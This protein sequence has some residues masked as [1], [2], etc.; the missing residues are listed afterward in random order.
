MTKLKKFIRKG[1]NFKKCLRVKLTN[2]TRIFCI[3]RNKTGTTSVYEALNRLG[4]HVA[5]QHPAEKLL[6]DWSRR[7]FSALIKF[8][9]WYEAFQ[10]VPFSFPYTFQEVDRAFPDAKF[11]LTI[12][13]TPEE[14]YQSVKRFHAKMF[15]DGSKASAAELKNAEYCYKG[16]I[17]DCQRFVYGIEEGQEYDKEI[18]IK[19]YEFH[20]QA[21]KDYFRWQSHKLLVLNVSEPGAY[22]KLAAFLNL[23]VDPNASFP[24]ENK[25]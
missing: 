13:N 25:T 21:I 14:W 3:G 16:Y 4:Y 1:V 18:Y 22:Q 15:S 17:W 10:D 2:P 7:D 6:K 8:C 24:W 9:T 5:P 11:I 23:Q 20:N 19:H 12:R